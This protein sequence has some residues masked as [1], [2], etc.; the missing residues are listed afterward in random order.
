MQLFNMLH[1][2]QSK[3]HPL[4][5]YIK[6][7][8]SFNTID[9]RQTTIFLLEL[10]SGTI[11]VTCVCLMLF[12]WSEER[13]LYFLFSR[14]HLIMIGE[15]FWTYLF[16]RTKGTKWKSIINKI[17]RLRRITEWASKW[18]KSCKVRG[19]EIKLNAE[20]FRWVFWKFWRCS[21]ITGKCH[22]FRST[23][24]RVFFENIMTHN[25]LKH[26]RNS[27]WQNSEE[28]WQIYYSDTPE[29]SDL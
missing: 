8:E 10:L 14:Q 20:N 22:R 7:W 16:L 6:N 27:F 12:S 25:M 23:L 17:C 15:T 28:N 13:H 1:Y 24:N 18:N 9:R 4:I 26:H 19:K 5:K 2:R 11:I 3:N 29:F 21:N